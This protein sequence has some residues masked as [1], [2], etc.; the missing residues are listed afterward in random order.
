MPVVPAETSTTS[1]AVLEKAL[2]EKPLWR[3]GR[4]Y[5]RETPSADALVSQSVGAIAVSLG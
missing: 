4:A 3:G 1:T 5:A 2:Y